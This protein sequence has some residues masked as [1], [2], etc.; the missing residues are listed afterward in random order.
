MGRRWWTDPSLFRMMGRGPAR[1][2]LFFI[3][4]AA[5]RPGPSDFEM[6]GRGPA[7]SITFSIFRC[8]ARPGPS[9]FQNSRPD[10]A[11][12]VTF[13]KTS[14]RP[15][16]SQFSGR[17]SPARPGPA[18][19]SKTRPGRRWWAGPSIFHLVG[20]GP[21]RPIIFRDDGPRPVPA[22]NFSDDGP[23]PG[24][25]HQISWRLECGQNLGPA[26]TGPSNV[27][28]LAPGPVRP[29]T[30]SKISARPGPGPSNFSYRPGSDNRS[31]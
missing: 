17:P 7:R 13:S 18:H 22:K 27:Q 14:A 20:R 4:W 5:A 28:I 25:A 30:F 16:P 3:W 10:P 2:I 29:I 23:R 1:P 26:R 19:R 8:P 6:M 12:P 15:G 9:T 24:P 21:A 11:R 31:I